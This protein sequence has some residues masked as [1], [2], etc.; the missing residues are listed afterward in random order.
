MTLFNIELSPEQITS[1]NSSPIEIELGELMVCQPFTFTVVFPSILFE[2][3]QAKTFVWKSIKEEGQKVNHILRSTEIVFNKNYNKIEFKLTPTKVGKEESYLIK[4]FSRKITKMIE[5]NISLKF[6]FTVHPDGFYVEPNDPELVFDEKRANIRT[7]NFYE[8]YEGKFRNED[9]LIKVE[10]DESM[11]LQQIS[12]LKM[13]RHQNINELLGYFISDDYK[14]HLIMKKP[15]T[16]YDKCHNEYSDEVNNKLLI[17]IAKALKYLHSQNI[18]HL[19]VKPFNILICETENGPIAKLNDFEISERVKFDETKSSES[20]GTEFF[21]SPEMK[22]GN[23]S[24]KSDIFSF[25]RLLLFIYLHLTFVDMMTIL[26]TER[27]GHTELLEN[28]DLDDK[29]K[30]LINRCC[31]ENPEN[32]TITFDEIIEILKSF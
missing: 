8:M 24:K 31:E 20:K 32:R 18:V 3:I 26:N 27:E 17:D 14:Y 30:D 4:I 28:S 13:L 21:I 16:T 1:E 12:I 15:K 5:T 25:G 2:T 9:V 10:I 19:D 6:K 23:F 22:N 7:E 29:R 11:S